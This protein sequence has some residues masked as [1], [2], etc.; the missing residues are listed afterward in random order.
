MRRLTRLT[1]AM[2]AG[3]ALVLGVASTPAGAAPKPKVPISAAVV[4]GTTTTTRYADPGEG[5]VLF[6]Q[7]VAFEV[8]G[9]FNGRALQGTLEYQVRVRLPGP[10]VA[11]EFLDATTQ[12]ATLTSNLGDLSSETSWYAIPIIGFECPTSDPVACGAANAVVLAFGPGTGDFAKLRGNELWT[13]RVAH[14]STDGNVTDGTLTGGVGLGFRY[15]HDGQVVT[16]PGATADTYET[17]ASLAM[18]G[19]ACYD[20]YD[21]LIPKANVP[22]GAMSLDYEYAWAVTGWTDTPDAL[23][24]VI[25]LSPGSTATVQNKAGSMTGV[26]GTVHLGAW[27]PE[28]TGDALMLGGP[29]GQLTGLYSSY[30]YALI[31]TWNI[32]ETFEGSYPL[33]L[34]TVAATSST[35]GIL[36]TY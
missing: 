31:R 16:E 6:D 20:E 10:G 30:T 12:S 11:A 17:R 4:S 25:T 27:P 28:A 26:V 7:S 21:N 13:M 15:C 29:W 18:I 1:M 33:G 32:T 14:T 35:V 23:E 19:S 9:T 34:T 3:G 2:V 36:A 24:P 8:E 22:G 5:Q